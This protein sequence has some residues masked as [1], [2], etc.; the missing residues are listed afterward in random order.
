MT[1]L[2][3]ALRCAIPLFLL[4]VAAPALAQSR[5]AGRVVDEQDR[6]V[7]AAIVVAHVVVAPSFPDCPGWR[8]LF[9]E[10]TSRGWPGP[11]GGIESNL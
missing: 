7:P 5:V 8:R 6:P 11:G 4:F 10:Y 9:P 3:A 2:H 1:A